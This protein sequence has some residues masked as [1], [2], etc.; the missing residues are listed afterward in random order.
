MRRFFWTSLHS[1][2]ESKDLW[3]RLVSFL[4]LYYSIGILILYLASRGSY[5]AKIIKESAKPLRTQQ[6]HAHDQRAKDAQVAIHRFCNRTF[7]WMDAYRKELSIKQAA[8]CI[9][10]QKRYRTISKR[11][12]DEWDNMQKQGEA[13]S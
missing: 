11:V 4:P 8:W 10:K 3:N 13:G 2:S 6:K 9:K 1:Y 5:V 7:R 12:M